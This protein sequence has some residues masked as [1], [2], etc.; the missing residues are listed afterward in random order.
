MAERLREHI[1]PGAVEQIPCLVR[2]R[3]PRGAGVQHGNEGGAARAAMSAAPLIACRSRSAGRQGDDD[4]ARG[5]RGGECRAFRVRRGVDDDQGEV[6]LACLLEC[7]GEPG[8]GRDPDY[9][10]VGF[11]G[12]GPSGG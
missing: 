3:A 12:V 9:R 8:R 2:E 1:E 10:I 7:A 11:A 4:E 6:L 5:A